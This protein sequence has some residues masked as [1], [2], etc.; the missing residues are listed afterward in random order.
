MNHH[1]DTFDKQAAKQEKL[2][3]GRGH[4]MRNAAG[5]TRDETLLDAL[6]SSPLFW[7][8]AMFAAI[9]LRLALIPNPGF[10]ADV[11][12]WKSWGLAPFDL[13][14]IN[15]IHR[16]NFNYPTPFIYLLLAMVK[17]YALFGDPHNFHEFWNNV[18]LPFLFISKMPAILAD[19]GIAAVFLWIGKHA[20]EIS[21]PPLSFAFYRLLAIIYLLHPI[22]LLDGAHWGQVDSLGVLLFLVAWLSALKNKPLLAGVI[23][24]VAMMTKLQNMIYGPIF[25]LFLWQRFGFDGLVKAVGGATLTFFAL[26]IEFLIGKDM[27]RVLASLTSNYDYFPWLSLNAYNPWWIVSGA[28]GMQVS[29]KIAAIGIVNAKAVGLTL[30]TGTYLLSCLLMLFGG[31]NFVFNNETMKQ[32][33]NGNNPRRE[34]I[35]NDQVFLFVTAVIIAASGFFLFQTQSHDRYA[36]PML[37]FLLLWFPL[38][39]HKGNPRETA[40]AQTKSF[41]TFFM[42]YSL[43]SI[44]YFFNLHNALIVN[45]PKNG[46]PFLNALN[47]PPL[48]IIASVIQTGF[49]FVF[50]YSVRRYIP[51]AVLVVPLA[52]VALSLFAKNLPLI[53]KKPVPVTAFAPIISTQGYGGRMINMPAQASFGFHEW[54]P[55]S[56]QYFFYRTGIGTHAVSRDVF[57]INKKFQKFT[58]DYGVDT[59]AGPQG[60]VVFVIYGDGKRLFE[61]ETIGRYDLPRHAEVGVA[62]VKMLE[63]ITTDAGGG[64]TDDHA[65]WLNP[66]LWP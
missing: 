47:I 30:F 46:I 64:I 35:I 44:I 27:P 21:F 49:F 3:L 59:R 51:K 37:V 52:Y 42:V 65:D 50:I 19:F 7:P 34:F 62:G 12:F 54:S 2:R 14:V 56:V 40:R 41:R 29:D 43:F 10:E 17:V 15:G 28:A 22:V 24:M 57:D 63:L 53:T 23:Y 13:G 58:F 55:L 45:Y 8:A 31:E 1:E 25:F 32:W 61:S 48:T 16:T 20:K 60:S 33:N 5:R 9:V 66:L 18:N 26:N 39:L 4:R 38:A 11:S 36:F 6:L